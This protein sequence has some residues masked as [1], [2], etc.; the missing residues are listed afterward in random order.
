MAKIYINTDAMI[1][2]KNNILK[3]IENIRELFNKYDNEMSLSKE[4]QIW[5]GD[6]SKAMYSKY[7]ELS[8]NY[9]T[10]IE[11]MKK[12]ADTI[13]KVANA[14]IEWDKEMIKLAETYDLDINNN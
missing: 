14:Y 6:A 2:D 12:I 5:F 8:S 13:G 10:I 9:D 11:S 1:S 3:R 4:K 7:E